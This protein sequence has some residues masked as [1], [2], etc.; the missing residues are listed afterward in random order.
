METII[1]A[2]QKKTFGI[3]TVRPV[4]ANNRLRAAAHPPYTNTTTTESSLSLLH[5]SPRQ[6]R[7]RITNM[8]RLHFPWLS[9]ADI[10]KESSANTWVVALITFRTAETKKYWGAEV[11]L[12][13]IWRVK[14]HITPFILGFSSETCS[15]LY[16]FHIEKDNKSNKNTLRNKCICKCM[17]YKA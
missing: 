11:L 6:R 14:K 16:G 17:T 8:N 15:Y 9:Y 2:A 13:W 3:N 4:I 1:T 7:K 5:K 12:I 10:S